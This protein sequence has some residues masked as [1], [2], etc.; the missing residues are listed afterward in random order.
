MGNVYEILMGIP[1][2]RRRRKLEN[3]IK[4]GFKYLGCENSDC[5]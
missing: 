3:N 1:E 4:M 5:I 2:G